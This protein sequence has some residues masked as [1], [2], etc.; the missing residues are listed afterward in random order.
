MKKILFLSLALLTF[1]IS[2]S[3]V[4]RCS[5]NEVE[6]ERRN[7]FPELETQEDFENW[8]QEKITE[9][10]DSRIIGGVYQIPVVFQ[11]I[12]NGESVGSGSN[13]SYAAALSQLDVLNED[14]R[15]IVGTR[16][17]NTNP[18]GADT[19]IEFCMAKRRPDGSAFPNNEDGVNRI[20]RTSA[21]FTAP[22][23]STTYINS[24][25]KTYTY[26]NGNPT[27][28]RG[29]HPRTYMNIWVLNISGG[30]LGYAQF[31]QSALGGMGCGSQSLATDGVVFTYTSIG[32]SSVTGFSAPY[33]EGRTATHEIGHW[34][35]LRHIWGDGG[36][37]VDDF[38]NDTPVAGY[39]NY[40]CPNNENSC[41]GQPGNDMIEN[42]MDY[43]DDLC[44][45]IFTQ[46]QKTRMRTV[47]ESSPLRLS[48]INSDACTP[49]N[50]ND[51]SIVDIFN[52]KGDNCPGSIVPSVQI[53]NRGGSNLTLANIAYRLNNGPVTNFTFSGNIIPGGTATIALPAFTSFLGN[54][55]LTVYSTLPNGIADPFP[56]ND[57]T[58]IDFVV[59]NGIDAPYT[60]NF[61]NDVFPPN[62]KWVVGNSN[63]DC[64]A[65]LGASATSIV[66]VNNNNTAQFPGFGN[67]SGGT[68]S[69]QTPIFVLPCNASFANIQFDVA[70][71]RRNNTAS[72]YD[73]LYIEITENCGTTW[74]AVPI[75]DKTGTALQV[76]T[77]TTNSYYTPIASNDWRTETI[78]L[79][80]FVGANSKNVKFRFR[81]VAANGNNI[82]LDNFKFN[83]SQSREINITQN[84]TTIF[85]EGG[86][87]YGIVAPG[88]NVQKTYTVTNTGSGNL[89]LTL[90]LN[91]SGTVFT[92][93]SSTL[94]NTLAAGQSATFTI[95]YTPVGGPNFSETLSL[96]NNDCDEG[97]YN[98]LLLG[99][100]TT[101]PPVADFTSN[102]NSTCVNSPI[103]F[104]NTTTNGTTYLWDFG[105][106]GIPSASTAINPTAS[107]T[108]V[109]VQTVT[110]TATNADGSDTEI[111]TN[112]I[113][114]TASNATALPFNEDFASA[115]FPSNSA[116]IVNLNSSANTWMR[117][118]TIGNTPSAG[119]SMIFNN[120]NFADDDDDEYRIPSLDLSGMTSAQMTFDLAYAAF[121]TTYF[122]GLEVLV[123]TDCGSTFTSEYLKTY[124][125]LETAPSTLASFIPA[126][127]EWRTETIDLSSYSGNGNVIIAIKNLAGNGNNLYIDN[128]NVTGVQNNLPPVAEFNASVTSIC[129][130]T[131]VTF[132]DQSTNNA[133]SYSWTFVGGTPNTSTDQNPSVSY[134]TSGIF[135]V[136]LEVTNSFGT[137]TMTKSSFINVNPQISSSVTINSDD[138]DNTICSGSLISFTASA[139]NGGVS[140]SY[141]WK[142]NGNN[143]GTNSPN[144]SSNLL[145]DNNV[146]SC[147]MT[148]SA[149]CAS[150]TAATSNFLT[151]SVLDNLTPT[152]AI[153]SSDVDNV[154]C[155]GEIILFSAGIT[156]GGN[157]PQYQWT[158]NGVGTG[159]SQDFL[160]TTLINGATVACE[161]ISN[162]TCL[163]SQSVTSTS[164]TTIVNSL[165]EPSISIT[166]NDADN[167]I[168]A[169]S[170]VIFTASAVNAGTT[171]SYQW[172][173]NGNNVGTN[174]VSYLAA[175]LLNGSIVNCEVTSNS[176]CA[177]NTTSVSSNITITVL[178]IESA[179]ATITSD[180]ADNIIAPNSSITFT[181]STTNAGL[182][183]TFQWFVNGLLVG[184]NTQTFTTS[185]LTNQSIVTCNVTSN[186]L[187]PANPVTAGNVL[188]I[189]VQNPNSI[190]E[191][192]VID[193]TNL[194]YPNP[195]S[196][197]FTIKNSDKFEG[198]VFIEITDIS[199]KIIDR[200]K[201]DSQ[202][203]ESIQFGQHYQAGMYTI[204]LRNGA[205]SNQVKVIKF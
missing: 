195:F 126:S 140:P 121:D 112:F 4:I 7:Q 164:I 106:N 162:E 192:N 75:Y 37:T 85:D 156:N 17:F 115:T 10:A 9:N 161:L 25:I 49:P 180:D 80:S 175:N 203:I 153:S 149:L 120:Y 12:H 158:I 189:L 15:R 174:N 65:W 187:C 87:D 188:T 35:G 64:Y 45:N 128:I 70:Y 5:T 131:A 14:F 55:R 73:R 167:S 27:A 134:T 82:Y 3:Q 168:C 145:T 99:A 196:N 63:S 16:G 84:G 165:S 33:N 139:S 204:S 21:G 118:S 150:P 13:V 125:D 89:S 50:L 127:N 90:P 114:T 151:I 81:A 147:V 169:G 69:L 155:D 77:S 1:N 47:L 185:T 202:D 79:L 42:Y 101:N 163:S 88:N 205:L 31:P 146:I 113:T 58:I 198:N 110:L 184:G 86:F 57:T 20:S 166:S 102:V 100:T 68:E 143:T 142:L 197:Y 96:T 53:K 201:V 38:C 181:A 157:S 124:L 176:T 137:N 26:N 83:A 61:E 32:K 19:E 116:S 105:P 186:A 152:I 41:T 51:A 8:I 46:D 141:Q 148:S 34:L 154:I 59:S 160:N 136:V 123:S 103:N 11:V 104:T 117:S 98:F 144:F 190:G 29:W 60:Q 30:T 129:E 107:F 194:I 18:V 2:N 28:T 182:N 173:L 178:A 193:L 78:D 132:Q 54:H 36:C 74:N 191:N 108:S 67:T 171:P 109:G 44:M 199:G 56:S 183:P 177:S 122:D 72:N 48:L 159:T 95:Q 119:N 170:S 22:P 40:G 138:L 66:G 43:T 111:K 6:A 130:N 97:I 62:I 179:T 39:A 71:R 23:F 172:T 76:I 93:V 133:T 24:T 92:L 200:L 94:T 52:P 135:D 91:I